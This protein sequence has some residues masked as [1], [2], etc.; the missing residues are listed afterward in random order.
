MGKRLD[1]IAAKHY[2]RMYER[3]GP[4]CNGCGYGDEPW[5]CDAALLLMHIARKEHIS[6]PG[7]D[8]GMAPGDPGDPR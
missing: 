2:P 8:N 5:P 4:Q 3:G 7:T 6:E 1:E